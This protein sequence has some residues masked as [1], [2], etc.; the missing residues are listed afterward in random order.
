M[1]MYYSWGNLGVRIAGELGMLV[2]LARW[3]I[4][5]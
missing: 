2:T 3:N 1:I 5:L 4:I